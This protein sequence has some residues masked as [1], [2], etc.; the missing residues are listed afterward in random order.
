MK[1]KLLIAGNEFFLV[2]S[3]RTQQVIDKIREGQFPGLV[4][5][6]STRGPVSVNLSKPVDFAL[7]GDTFSDGQG[8]RRSAITC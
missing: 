5:V 2:N 8:K 1:Y 4:T 3:A 6:D 7:T